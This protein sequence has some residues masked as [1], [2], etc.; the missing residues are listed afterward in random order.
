M[1]MR[2]AVFSTMSFGFFTKAVAVKPRQYEYTKN[3]ATDSNPIQLPPETCTETYL[4]SF[5]LSCC[6]KLVVAIPAYNEAKTLGSVL[7]G[8]HKVLRAAKQSHTILVIDDGSSDGTVGVARKHGAKVV[9]HQVNLGLAETFRTAMK[10]CLQINPDVIVHIDADGQYVPHE[11]PKLLGKVN[12]GYDLVLGSR[13]AGRIEYMP[14]IKRWGN[15]AFSKVVSRITRLRIT[16]GQTGFRAFT[17]KVAREVQLTSDHTYTQEQI[18]RAA[19]QKFRIAEVPVRFRRRAD[20]SRLISNP[21]EYAI[22]AWVNLLRVYRDYEPLRFFG[23]LGLFFILIGVGVGIL[24]VY[25][26]LTKGQAGGIPRV[27]LSALAIMTGVQIMLFGFL[28][29][30][31]R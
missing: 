31:K 21:F 1:P 26:I 16:D 14:L 4:N 2:I 18:I 6:V 5:L 9:S 3:S 29:D 25:N 11:I 23:Y 12:E 27:V 10:V 19:K 17:T 28:A 7:D 24:V 22:R 8:I 13:F 15:K 20:R 30:M